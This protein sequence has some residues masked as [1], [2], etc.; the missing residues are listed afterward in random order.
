MTV[1]RRRL[2]AT[3][4]AAL[5]ATAAG[6]A[7]S[8]FWPEQGLL[9]PCLGP[10]PPELASHSLVGE[11][12]A[13]LDPAEVWD[14]H[15]HILGVG[16]SGGDLGFNRGD[17]IVRWPIAAAQEYFFRNAVCADAEQAGSL[18]DALLARLRQLMAAMP[19]GH[20]MLLLAL[21][22]WH[23]EGGRRH[24][25]HTHFWVGNDYCAQFVQRWPQRFEWVASVHPYRADA[26]AEIERAHRLGARALKWIPSAQGIDP[27]SA[28]CDAAYAAMAR[29][30]LP[31]ITH[32]GQER[33]APGDD[34]LGNPLRLRRA[35]EHGVRVVVAHCASMGEDR[36][37]DLGPGGPWRDSFALFERMMNEPAHVGRLFGDLSAITQTARAGQP[38]R[39]VLERAFED[40]QGSGEWAGRLLN[41]SD[42]PLPAAMPLYSPRALVAGGLLDAAAAEPLSAI[43]R[44]NPLLFDFV[45]KRHLRLNGRRLAKSVFTTRRFFAPLG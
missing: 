18:D 28:R 37:I 40:G 41:G 20:K 15:A 25:E 43:R 31:L 23:D 11:A 10:L 45:L 14:A 6:L 32:G 42:Y 36:D 4:G 12:W 34:S 27:A 5:A 38:L 16:D 8:R 21:D 7:A 9:N 13:G 35:L 3:T 39:R 30:N 33:A 19:A 17:S 44:H 29:L 2:L 24:S 26:V 1:S 22:A